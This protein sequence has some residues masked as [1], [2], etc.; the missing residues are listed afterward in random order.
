MNVQ[1][2]PLYN[3]F[4]IKGL[5]FAHKLIELFKDVVVNGEFQ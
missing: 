5:P 2:N 4:R 1:E 3:K